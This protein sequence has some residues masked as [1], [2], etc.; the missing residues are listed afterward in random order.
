M[1]NDTL[2]ILQT[3][4]AIRRLRTEKRDRNFRQEMK[5]IW[6]W[7]LSSKSSPNWLRKI[8]T[9]Y[10]WKQLYKLFYGYVSTRNEVNAMRVVRVQLGWLIGLVQDPFWLLVSCGR[11]WLVGSCCA[12]IVGKRI[13]WPASRPRRVQKEGFI[14]VVS[15]AKSVVKL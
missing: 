10:R 12:L 13:A 6:Q 15:H 8:N 1:S 7:K 3:W 11:L 2:K 4:H 14:A 5:R 9:L